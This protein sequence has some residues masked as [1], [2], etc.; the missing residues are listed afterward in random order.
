MKRCFILLVA[1]LVALCSNS[2]SAQEDGKKAFDAYA[3]F[4]VGGTWTT[5]AEGNKLEDTYR[6]VQETHFVRLTSK[7]SD[8]FPG[9][10]STLGVDPNT[11]KFTWWGFNSDGSLAKGIMEYDGKK[12]WTGAWDSK[13]FTGS[14]HMELILKK[15]D[16]DTLSVEMTNQKV[17]GE[18]NEFPTVTEWKRIRK[19]KAENTKE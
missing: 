11:G 6:R 1:A 13:G 14:S 10:F 19:G 3:K 5:T 4:I 2:S 15:I 17:D 18:V 16:K 9:G 8:K 7:G 12:T